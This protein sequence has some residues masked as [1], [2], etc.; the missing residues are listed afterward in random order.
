MKQIRLTLCLLI[1]LVPLVAS[2]SAEES[3]G[4]IGAATG[5]AWQDVKAGSKE[6]WDGVSEGSKEAWEATKKGSGKAWEATKEG[7]GKVRKSVGKVISG[8]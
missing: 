4:S 5:K 7:A 3:D 1:C 2:L 8:E 6:V